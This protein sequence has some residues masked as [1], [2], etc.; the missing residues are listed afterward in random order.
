MKIIV[1]QTVYR[2][3]PVLS[4]YDLDANE[5][6]RNY[7]ILNIGVRKAKA[8]LCATDEI[9][10]FINKNEEKNGK[11]HRNIEEV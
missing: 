3:R 6:Y 5:E 10:K 8:I 9:K 11:V 7:P 2:G 4:I 1:K